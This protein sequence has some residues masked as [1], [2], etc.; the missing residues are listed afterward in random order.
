MALL[1]KKENGAWEEHTKD[2][3]FKKGGVWQKCPTYFKRDGEWELLGEKEAGDDDWDG[4][5]TYPNVWDILNDFTAT[6]VSKQMILT[7]KTGPLREIKM[8]TVYAQTPSGAANYL[9]TMSYFW[10]ASDNSGS[11]SYWYNFQPIPTDIEI[12][13]IYMD[14]KGL[15]TYKLTSSSSP[16]DGYYWKTVQLSLDGTNWV[17]SGSFG[18]KTTY[19]AAMTGVPLKVRG[20]LFMRFSG[21]YKPSSL[22]TANSHRIRKIILQPQ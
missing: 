21:C 3:F 22:Q 16:Y 18:S 8:K 14:L 17:A 20:K 12:T 15:V 11:N 13:G 19:V 1:Y 2:L 9:K 5:A 7:S 10:G 4:V 6:L